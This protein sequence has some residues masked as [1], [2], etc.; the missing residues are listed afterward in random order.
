M[1]ITLG[2]TD[3][4]D[5]TVSYGKGRGASMVSSLRNC[6]VL[7]TVCQDVDKAQTDISYYKSWYHRVLGIKALR[8][9]EASPGIQ[10]RLALTA[11][12]PRT[13]LVFSSFVQVAVLPSPHRGF[14]LHL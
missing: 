5:E 9:R 8:G 11:A 13:L 1:D 12:A 3:E 10:T 6:K 4:R 2:Q 7:A 14:Q